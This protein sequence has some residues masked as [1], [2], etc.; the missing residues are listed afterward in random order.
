M[1]KVHLKSKLAMSGPSIFAKISGLAKQYDAIN[2]GQGFPNFD[3]PDKLKELTSKHL[4]E[5]K[6]QYAP[7]PGIESLR[8]GIGEKY[9]DLYQTQINSN[10]EITITSGATQALF[11]VISAIVNANDEVIIFEPAYDSYRPT[12]EL[13][14]GNVMPYALNYPDYKID[15]NRVEN[16]VSAKTKM[17]IVNTPH[18][19]TGTTWSDSDWKS[20][21]SIVKNT[22]II[23]LSDEVYEHIV[24]DNQQ[25][26]SILNYPNLYERG[27]A[28]FSFGKTYHNTGWKMGYAIAPDYI[29]RLIR[30]VHQWN[31]F[32]V[33]SFVQYALADFI[34]EKDFYLDLPEFYQKKRDL[35]K[36]LMKSTKFI[37]LPSQ[38]TY[39]QLYDYGEISKAKDTIFAEELI[40]KYKVATIPI[41]V[42]YSNPPEAK[43]V[44]FCFAKTDDIVNEAAE[45]LS[46]IK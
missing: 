35:L 31:V 19:P 39:F 27:V 10:N 42:F 16:M 5:N 25:H 33:N 38:G 24:F 3:C 20:L 40:R 46:H 44:R 34:K 32:S 12:I 43:V 28:V 2:L 36:E 4:M 7:M 22:G 37:P 1:S 8:M 17:I 13:N 26:C 14:G 29:T 18:N 6:N 41:S 23:V 15:W 21:E 45:K 11:V 30:N 9:N